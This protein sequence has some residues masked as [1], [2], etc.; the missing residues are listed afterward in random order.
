M[1]RLS[2][3]KQ[4]NPWWGKQVNIHRQLL[5]VKAGQ[6]KVGKFENQEVTPI[7]TM[8]TKDSQSCK[9]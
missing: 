6:T 8:S 9:T 5:E 1:I 7:K 4:W 2:C 3:G